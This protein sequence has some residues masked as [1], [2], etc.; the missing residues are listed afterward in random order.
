MQ[1]KT[2]VKY[3]LTPIKIATIKKKKEKPQKINDSKDVKQLET[4]CT[5][6]GIIK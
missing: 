1:I 5:V 6:D 4:L 2:I 3:H